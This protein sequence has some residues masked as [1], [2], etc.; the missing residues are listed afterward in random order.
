M[1]AHSH[2]LLDTDQINPETIKASFDFL[3]DQLSER[4]AQRPV[5]PLA[6]DWGTVRLEVAP[7]PHN[8]T[9]R[10]TESIVRL[11]AEVLT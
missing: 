4:A 6:L 3:V 11:S 9:E 2:L 7:H 1:R 10:P 8:P 5:K